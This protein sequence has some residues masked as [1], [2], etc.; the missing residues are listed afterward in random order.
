MFAAFA[1]GDRKAIHPN[2]RD[3][4]YSIALRN[5]GE[6]EFDVLLHEFRTAKD[7][8]EKNTALRALGRAKGPKLIARAIALPLSD[9]VKAQDVYAPLIGMRSDAE[10]I[11][12]LWEWMKENWLTIKEK[13]PPALTMLGTMVGRC[14]ASFTHREHVQ[15]VQEFFESKDKKGF[16]K[17]LEQSL[18]GVR[19]KASWLERDGEDVRGWLEKEG[20]LKKELKI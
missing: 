1:A 6:R 11:T 5:G 12:A 4:V 3:S 20:L 7:A 14:T 8:D 19:A 10:G 16:E 2:I 17:K 13:C 9:E 15:A 18:D